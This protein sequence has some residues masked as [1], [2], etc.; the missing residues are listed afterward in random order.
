MDTIDRL[1]GGWLRAAQ[2]A[3]RWLVTLCSHLRAR[4]AHGQG[5]VEY[6]LMLV[7][8]AIVVI[9]ILSSVGVQTSEV[10]GQ[11]NCSLGGGTYHRD[12]GNGNSSRCQ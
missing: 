5:L 10:F 7:L 4:Q 9:G 8:I 3:I 2:D 12:Q 1:L 6:A 11:V